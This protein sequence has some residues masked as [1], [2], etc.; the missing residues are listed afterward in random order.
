MPKR[1]RSG[2]D[3]RPGRVVAPMKVKGRISITWVRAAGPW[4]MMMSS[5]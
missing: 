5:L 3:S 2:D 4:P 1:E